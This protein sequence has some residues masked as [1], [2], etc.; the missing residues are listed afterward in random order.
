MKRA[1][2][3][4]EGLDL[5]RT[6]ALYAIGKAPDGVPSDAHYQRI[7]YLA[8]KILGKDP[9]RDA[10]YGAHKHGPYSYTVD[11]W[12]RELLET[13]RL[14]KDE[15]SERVHVNPKIAGDVS[16][17]SPPDS[18]KGLMIKDAVEFLCSLTND[19]LLLVAY[20]DDSINGEGMSSNSLVVDEVLSGRA[21][22]AKRMVRSDKVT[23]SRGAELADMDIAEFKRLVWEMTG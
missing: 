22:I 20:A 8:L 18:L 19:E 17:I 23:L 9:V 11:G 13:G 1:D 12:K 5:A 4:V 6:L 10:Q 16:K 2:S 14:M 15:G 21:D 7:M 3:V